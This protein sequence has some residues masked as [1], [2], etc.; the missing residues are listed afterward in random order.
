MVAAC[1]PNLKSRI[2][3]VNGRRRVF[4]FASRQLAPGEEVT[5]ALPS[6][7]DL[8]QHWLVTFDLLEKDRAEAHRHLYQAG[9]QCIASWHVSWGKEAKVEA[10]CLLYLKWAK[11]AS[12]MARMVWE[13]DRAD[14][15]ELGP[16]TLGLMCVIAAA[17][18]RSNI[19]A[20]A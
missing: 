8:V 17:C 10:P 3:E 19:V 2:V 18:C 1:S 11:I 13:E 9:Q 15:T 12:P 4:Y 14:I 5:C 20:W 16:I 7:F 6:M